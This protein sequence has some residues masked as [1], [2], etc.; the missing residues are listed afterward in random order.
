KPVDQIK[1]S[2]LSYVPEFDFQASRGLD[3][4]RNNV[5]NTVHSSSNTVRMNSNNAT[6]F[7]LKSSLKRNNGKNVCIFENS[8]QD[9]IGTA[10][11]I[12]NIVPINGYGFSKVHRT[13]VIEDTH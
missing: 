10:V 7:A 8:P 5:S 6:R 12:G 4:A 3:L 1:K 11:S 9:V 13:V 2:K